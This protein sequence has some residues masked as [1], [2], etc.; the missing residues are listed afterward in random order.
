MCE[1]LV[2]QFYKVCEHTRRERKREVT[3]VEASCHLWL[4]RAAV[5]SE[6]VQANFDERK[7]FCILWRII[8]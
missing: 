7:M 8:F 2:V 5:K 3:L 6:P 4:Q 1:L